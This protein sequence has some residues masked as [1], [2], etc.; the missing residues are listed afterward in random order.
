MV[1]RSRA[2]PRSYTPA[3]AHAR[4]HSKTLTRDRNLPTDT[5]H[6]RDIANSAV[7]FEGTSDGLRAMDITGNSYSLNEPAVAQNRMV[8]ATRSLDAPSSHNSALASVTPQNDP[9]LSL[10]R[11]D[12]IRYCRL[13][14]EELGLMYPI[15]DIERTI[16]NANIL[17]DFVDSGTRTGLLCE[18]DRTAAFQ[19][20]DVH[21]LKLILAVALVVEGFCQSRLGKEFFESVRGVVE[22]LLWQ[23]TSIFGL[24]LLVLAVRMHPTVVELQLKDVT[25]RIIIFIPTM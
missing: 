9:L 4:H 6:S 21:T 24:R 18:G 23:P 5:L 16:A 13:Y 11:H 19:N 22:G 3:T 15:L 10:Q 25:R 7:D 14:E 2:P 8:S 1:A 17:L 20:N 12:I